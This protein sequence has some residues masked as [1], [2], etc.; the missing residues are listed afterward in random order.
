MKKMILMAILVALIFPAVLSAGEIR[1]TPLHI[2]LTNPTTDKVEL[3][4]QSY[5][6]GAAPYLDITY[7][8]LDS[9]G[10]VRATHVLR[11]EGADFTAFVGGI[12]A[13]MVSRGD[14]AVWTD[15]QGKYAVQEMP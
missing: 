10:S 3:I 13:T 9:N 14:T 12:I 11:V 1:T 2:V 4:S 15:I 6:Y 8:V 5:H 7:N